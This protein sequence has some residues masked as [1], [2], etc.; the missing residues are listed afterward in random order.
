MGLTIIKNA[1]LALTFLLELGV[2]VALGFGGF[3]AEQGT[4]AKIALGLGAPAAAAG[5]WGLFGAPRARWHLK[6]VFRVLLQIVF[7]GSAALA[8]YAAVSLG[9]GLAWALVCI[10][11]IGLNYAWRQ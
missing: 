8:L 4:I 5:A 10:I 1:N 6:G 9:L 2:L 11:N 7:F 3:Q